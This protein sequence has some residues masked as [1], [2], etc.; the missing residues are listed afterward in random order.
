MLLGGGW[1]V[2][3]RM[4]WFKVRVDIG[5]YMINGVV[6]GTHLRMSQQR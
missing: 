6:I 3:F 5:V 4:V 1:S 2:S